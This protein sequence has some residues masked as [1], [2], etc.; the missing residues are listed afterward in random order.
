MTAAPIDKEDLFEF[1]VSRLF[2]GEE[3]NRLAQWLA[4]APPADVA[5]WRVR[6]AYAAAKRKARAGDLEP[7]QQILVDLT[8]DPELAAFIA[9]PVTPAWRSHARKD[10]AAA[11]PF[12][13]HAREHRGDMIRDIRELVQEKVGARRVSNAL[14]VEIAA[15]VL[16][17]PEAE[18]RTII[19]RGY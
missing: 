11:M 9:Q 1:V 18:I 10:L 17:C 7:L 16:N 13:K 6:G 15:K 19:K 12:V 4:T 5:Q 8:G 2:G 3:D 14:V